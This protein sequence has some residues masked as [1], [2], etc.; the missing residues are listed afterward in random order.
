MMLL[1]KLMVLEQYIIGY[2]DARLSA[3][4]KSILDCGDRTPFCGKLVLDVTTRWNSIYNMIRRALDAKEAIDLFILRERE[5]EMIFDEECETIGN[6]CDYLE[7][8]Y[9]ITELFSGT[10]YP[11][12]NSYFAC[13]IKFEKLIYDSH[14]DPSN[15]VRNMAKPVWETFDKLALM[16]SDILAIPI[17]S[18]ASKSTFSA[19]GQILN[20]LRSYLLPKNIEILVMTRSLLFGFKLEKNDEEILSVAREATTDDVANE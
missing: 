9:D 13:V 7:P 10:Q 18:F 1:Q 15:T 8:F 4:D 6:I 20:K 11:T 14:K 3:F 5:L 19:G 17:T 2:S 12:S 16:A